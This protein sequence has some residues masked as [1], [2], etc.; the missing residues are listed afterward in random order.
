MDLRF[1]LHSIQDT[2]S[3]RGDLLD[4]AVGSFRLPDSPA[5]LGN[6][7]HADVEGTCLDQAIR[8]CNRRP[9]TMD[10]FQNSKS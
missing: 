3:T 1:R 8:V 6:L 7:P 10:G 2:H 4:D 5:E 9:Q